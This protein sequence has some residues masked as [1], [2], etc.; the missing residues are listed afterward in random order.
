MDLLHGLM[1]CFYV[2]IDVGQKSLGLISKIENSK[3]QNSKTLTCNKEAASPG[4]GFIDDAA[5]INPIVLIG[6]TLHW[7]LSIFLRV[8]LTGPQ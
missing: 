8:K 2:C 3:I 5:V 7:V 4:S 1:K 6:K